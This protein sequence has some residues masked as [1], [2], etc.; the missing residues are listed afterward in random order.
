MGVPENMAALRHDL[1]LLIIEVGQL[2][3]ITPEDIGDEERLIRGG[4]KFDL[5]SL[6]ALEIAAAIDYRYHVKI[7]DLSSAKSI[8]RS[9]ASL[10]DHVARSRGWEL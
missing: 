1:K 10:A 4:G 5:G 8:F 3:G 9:V 7:Q 6:D 2:D